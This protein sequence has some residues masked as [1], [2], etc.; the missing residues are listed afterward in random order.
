M[1]A[2]NIQAQVDPYPPVASIQGIQSPNSPTLFDENVQPG[3]D[4]SLQESG[5]NQK[6]PHMELNTSNICQRLC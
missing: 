2:I 1:A 3:L 6:I 4:S 5:K